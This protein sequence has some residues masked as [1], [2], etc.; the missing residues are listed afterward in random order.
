MTAA[1]IKNDPRNYRRRSNNGLPPRDSEGSKRPSYPERDF[2]RAPIDDGFYVDF[3]DNGP[4]RAA[5]MNE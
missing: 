1:R 5:S 4:G 3:S 2:D